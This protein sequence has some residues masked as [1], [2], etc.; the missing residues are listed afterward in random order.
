MKLFGSIRELVRVVFRQNAQ[1]IEFDSNQSTTYTATRLHQLP[2]GDSS[3]I[4][5]SETATQTLTNK[6]FDADGTGNSLSNV[7][8]GNIKALAGINATK[9]ADG[10][11]DNTEFQALGA[12]GTAGAGNL[13]TTDGTQTLTNKT[14]DGDNNTVQDLALTSLKTVLGD[15][16]KVIRRDASGVVISGNALPNSS[17]LVTTD[18]TQAL[19]NKTIDGDLNTVQ[20]LPETAIKTNITNAS[21]FFTRDASGVPES[22]TKA[23][24]TG[25]VVGT[26]D[27]QT[28]TNK[29]LT[30]PTINGGTITTPLIND[31]ADFNEESVPATP[32]ANTSRMYVKAD[33]RFYNKDDAG[34]EYGPFGAS[35]GSAESVSTQT[36]TDY[37]ILDNDGFT[38]ILV[39][40]GNTPRVINLPAV[41]N[42]SNRQIKI[43]KIDSGTGT[44]TVTRDGTSLIDGATTY[45]LYVQYDEITTQANNPGTAWSIIS[46]NLIINGQIRADTGVAATASTDTRIARLVNFVTVG[47]AITATDNATNGTIFT[48]NQ[49]GIYAISYTNSLSAAASADHGI[50]LNATGSLTTGVLALTAAL[51]LVGVTTP[52]STSPGTA[53]VTIR[54]VPT[55]AIR[56]HVSVGTGWSTATSVQFTIT[57]VARF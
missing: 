16:D 49:P 19:T 52:G 20:D 26:T 31:Y 6:T 42:N 5:V 43:K 35:G 38:T 22:A 39:S 13:V 18:S 3:Q 17:A 51:R 45:V 56:P 41:A 55:D 34:T 28:L 2:P 32:S 33:G 9:I 53:A 27:T 47:T 12:A 7:D 57:Q 11:V 36:N 54:L 30:T 46:K 10:S 8:D 24:P 15:A 14:I 44:V 25:V 1:E 21:K 50:S 40:T 23:V 29:T 4:L 48:I 37:T